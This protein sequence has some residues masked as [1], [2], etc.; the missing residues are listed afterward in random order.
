[1][2]Q[3]AL[4]PALVTLALATASTAAAQVPGSI[5][6][7]GYL[8]DADGQPVDGPTSIEIDLYDGN[9]SIH[10]ETHQVD[11]DQGA[12][13]VHFGGGDLDLELFR[14]HDDLSIGVS[15]DGVALAP[16][17]D[18]GAVPYAAY[19]H[20]CDELVEPL[21]WSSLAGVPTYVSDGDDDALGDLACGSGQ[22]PV[23]NGAAWACS[24]AAGDTLGNLSCGQGQVPSYSGSAWTCANQ[25]VDTNTTYTAGNGLTLAGTTLS[26]DATKTQA[27]VTGTCATGSAV[28]A[29]DQL[30]AV[31]CEAD[32]DTTYTV[33]AGLTL[34]AQN[35][36]AV[37]AITSAMITD[38]VIVSADI[39]NGEVA[40][41][42]L[43]NL[44]VT[45]AKLAAD[46]VTGPKIVTAAVSREKI[47]VNAVD[48]ARL[49]DIVPGT[50]D[51]VSASANNS[52]TNTVERPTSDYD[53]CVLAFVNFAG[54]SGACRVEFKLAS[55]ALEDR[56][57]L[58][59]TAGTNDIVQCS[60]M[61]LA[62]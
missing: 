27:R 4:C 32:D 6:I 30:G 14:D 35:Q 17:F 2:R 61:C 1:M 15:V 13:I 55:G 62:W 58:T 45:S 8:T 49:E 48:T 52:A 54:D 9:V 19:S 22:V 24:N 43:A 56:W 21:A 23:F 31:T 11:V 16:R 3:H 10:A 7:Q 28:R 50:R 18:L 25:T 26:A 12:F 5:P 60:M 53:L 41:E 44:A 42:D 40:T 46:S 38:G 51:V 47:A 37:S 59:A 29:I 34:S 20:Y 36:I 39:K 57:T 33:G